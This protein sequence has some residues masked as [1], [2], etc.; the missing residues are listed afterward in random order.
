MLRRR[1]RILSLACLLLILCGCQHYDITM[2][3]GDVIRA[4]SKPKLNAEGYYVFKDLSGKEMQVKS[5]RIRQ[6]QPVRAGSKPSGE[7][8]NPK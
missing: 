3:N 5:M 4:R 8:F 1:K 6:I 7:F 2:S